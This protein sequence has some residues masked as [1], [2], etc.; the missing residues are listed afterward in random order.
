MPIN[1]RN[2]N[3]F[4][5]TSDWIV[6]GYQRFTFW[7]LP[8]SNAKS[9]SL[10]LLFADVEIKRRRVTLNLL[11]HTYCI[12]SS[13]YWKYC[14]CKFEDRAKISNSGFDKIFGI[15]LQGEIWTNFV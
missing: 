13:S 11:I 1:C 2:D 6:R 5:W 10:T 9:Y 12:I 3:K 15:H 4:K 8:T 7:K 14:T